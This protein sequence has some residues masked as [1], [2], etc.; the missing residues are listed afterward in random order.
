MLPKNMGQ[1]NVSSEKLIKYEGVPKN[2]I[3]LCLL[4]LFPN[5]LVL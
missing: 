5:I 4:Q 2:I 1:K 3:L